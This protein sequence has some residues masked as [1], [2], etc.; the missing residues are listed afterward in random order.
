VLDLMSSSV[1]VLFQVV[2]EFKKR[3]GGKGMGKMKW[4]AQVSECNICVCNVVVAGDN[5]S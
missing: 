4:D 5:S 3:E 2:R 1:V